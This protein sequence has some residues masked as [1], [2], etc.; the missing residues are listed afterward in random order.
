MG[1]SHAGPERRR[2]ALRRGLRA[3]TIARLTLALKG[4]RLL[5]RRYGGKGGEIDLIM[6]RGRAIVFVEVK[7]RDNLDA[8]L[9]A[10]GPAKH[11]LFS[12]TAAQW[13]SRNPWAVDLDLRADAVL[14]APGRWPRHIVAAF[15]MRI[16]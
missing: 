8:A 5:A 16:G 1:R 6:Q 10:I 13:L 3:E 15:E 2:K 11:R 7:A 4:Y 9:E 14:V 12:R